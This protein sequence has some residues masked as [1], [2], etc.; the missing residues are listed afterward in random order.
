MRG[1][2]STCSA[3][4]PHC[5]YRSRSRSSRYRW[6]SRRC[7]WR[8]RRQWQTR[9][10]YSKSPGAAEQQRRPCLARGGTAPSRRPLARGALLRPCGGGRRHRRCKGPRTWSRW[11]SP[12]TPSRRP[13]LRCSRPRHSPLRR[14]RR[15]RRRRCRPSWPTWCSK[16]ATRAFPRWWRTTNRW[17]DHCGQPRSVLLP[18]R[19]VP[20]RG[21]EGSCASSSLP[22]PPDALQGPPPGWLKQRR[23]RGWQQ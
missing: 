11:T 3:Y 8:S 10:R 14:P 12:S 21:Q 4:A 9:P 7:R 19:T 20:R 15:P 1:R 18:C 13:R 17:Q 16:C 2:C 23:R 5:C 22:R 6:R